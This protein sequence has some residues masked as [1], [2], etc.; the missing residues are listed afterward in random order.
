MVSIQKY[1]TVDVK[2]ISIEIFHKV[3]GLTTGKIISRSV[4]DI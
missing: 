3:K 1:E 2:H 4:K